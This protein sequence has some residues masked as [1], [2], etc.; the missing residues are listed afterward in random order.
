MIIVCSLQLQAAIIIFFPEYNF[1]IHRTRTEVQPQPN[2]VFF[3]R[4]QNH[5]VPVWGFMGQTEQ[6]HKVPVW[7]FRGKKVRS[8]SPRLGI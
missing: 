3:Q 1:L 8:S 2:F 7:G 4:R 5:K 6:N